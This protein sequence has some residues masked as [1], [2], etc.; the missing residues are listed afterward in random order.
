MNK[1]EIKLLTLALDKGAYAAEAESAAVMLIRKL[2]ARNATVDEFKDQQYPAA[3]S[4][5]AETYG[6]VRM[7]FGKYKGLPLADIPTDYLVWVLENCDNVT[8]NLRT[9]IINQVN[10]NQDQG[11]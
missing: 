3:I 11:Q 9:A 10:S 8:F 7:P 1:L 2:R 4:S 6:Y 5:S